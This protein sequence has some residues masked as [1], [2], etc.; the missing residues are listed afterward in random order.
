MNCIWSYF[1]LTLCNFT[2]NFFIIFFWVQYFRIRFNL[3]LPIFLFV[4]C[5]KRLLFHES[6]LYLLIFSINFLE[7]NPSKITKSRTFC[8][9]WCERFPKSFKVSIHRWPCCFRWEHRWSLFRSDYD[10]IYKMSTSQ[11]N[12]HVKWHERYS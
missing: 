2:S 7:I 12:T 6:N 10:F 8:Q 11:Y 4:V 1:Y 9:G 3:C 5:N